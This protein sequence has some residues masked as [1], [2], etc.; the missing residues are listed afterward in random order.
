M[1]GAIPG[2]AN[3]VPAISTSGWEAG[4]A[5]DTETARNCDAQLIAASRIMNIAGGGGANAASFSGMKSALKIM[6]VLDSDTVSRPLRP[7]TDEEKQRIPAILKE[8][9]LLN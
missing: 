4:E 6:G 7:L 2:L 8:L 9:D 1:H 5:G 3:L